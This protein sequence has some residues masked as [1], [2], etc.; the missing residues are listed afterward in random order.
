MPAHEKCD[1][2]VLRYLAKLRREL[3]DHHGAFTASVHT[4]ISD[5]LTVF[6]RVFFHA[7][8]GHAH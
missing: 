1:G 2:R 5:A 3:F 6:E 4:L 7:A 8:R